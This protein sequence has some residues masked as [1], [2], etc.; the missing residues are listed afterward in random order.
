M[1]FNYIITFIGD[2][3]T[4][5]VESLAGV[6][7]S[8]GGNWLESQ[9]SQLK[10]K[11][12]GIILIELPIDSSD[13]L[14]NDLKAMP[15]GSWSV[16]VTPAGT[17]SLSAEQANFQLAVIGPDRPGI[18]REISKALADSGI[19]VVALETRVLNAAFTGEAMFHADIEV[20]MPDSTLP[21]DLEDRLDAIAEAM[22]LDID[23]RQ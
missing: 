14:E 15:D 8:H 6:V 21:R 22:T 19:S 18:V 10:G 13:D 4:G 1:S 2:D 23:I 7:D 16:R 3:R 11:F 5:I 20:L 17:A 12:A 9:L